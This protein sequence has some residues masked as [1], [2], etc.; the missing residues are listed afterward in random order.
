M[1]MKSILLKI[2]ISHGEISQYN[3]HKIKTVLETYKG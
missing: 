2:T 3:K 1:D